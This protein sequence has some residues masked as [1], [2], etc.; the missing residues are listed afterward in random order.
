MSRTMKNEEIEKFESVYGFQPTPVGVALDA[1]ALYVHRDNPLKSI[2]LQEVD[3]I[4]SKTRKGGLLEIASWGQ[5]GLPDPW[6]DK[7]ISLYGRNSASGTYGYFK[8]KA[9]FRGDFKNKVKEQP[10]SAS[11]VM[12]I[13][14]DPQ[15]MGYCGIGYRTSGVKPLLLSKLK[16][17][18]SY[19]PNYSNVL[20]G[21]YPLGRMLYVYVIK[22]PQQSLSSLIRAFLNFVLSER[23]QSIVLKDGYMKLTPQ[24]LQGQR[25]LLN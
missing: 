3:A 15:G 4:F 9:L 14:E 24:Q 16:G 12:G 23:G 18:R 7:S 25:L 21:D 1:L 22:K 17:S 10:G 8:T 11:V 2:S 5:I 13:S 19:E 6:N 20:S